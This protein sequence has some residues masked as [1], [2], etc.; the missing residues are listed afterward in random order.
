MQ[1]KK[2]F[3]VS[4]SQDRGVYVPRADLKQWRGD[5]DLAMQFGF[6]RVLGSICRLPVDRAVLQLARSI[7]PSLHLGEVR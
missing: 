1:V 3:L 4:P 2:P 6:F 5:L 7:S